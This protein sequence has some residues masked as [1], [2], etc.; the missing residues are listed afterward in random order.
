MKPKQS[1]HQQWEQESLAEAEKC[2][3]DFTLPARKGT[4]TEHVWDGPAAL[5]VVLWFQ[6]QPWPLLSLHYC[7]PN[8]PCSA[9]ASLRPPLQP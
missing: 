8:S 1:S 3:G 7:L 4:C 2:W 5:D 9:L 6:P